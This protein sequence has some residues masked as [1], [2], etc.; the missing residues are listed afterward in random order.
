[1]TPDSKRRLPKCWLNWAKEYFPFDDGKKLRRIKR[2]DWMLSLERVA[3]ALRSKLRMAAAGS[4]VVGIVR[5]QGEG[6]AVDQ[7]FKG[8]CNA[9]FGGWFFYSW[10]GI[11]QGRKPARPVRLSVHGAAKQAIS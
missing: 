11:S 5:L 6:P 1:M 8:I 4:R 2:N 9:R 10:G 3:G 7:L